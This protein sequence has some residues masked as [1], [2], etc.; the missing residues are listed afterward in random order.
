MKEIPDKDLPWGQW[1]NKEG[2]IDISLTEDGRGRTIMHRANC[3]IVRKAAD[4][5]KQV[6]TM[7]GCRGLPE[8]VRRCACLEKE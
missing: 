5:G 2:G 8:G 6:F 4:N 3:E 1:W 7:L